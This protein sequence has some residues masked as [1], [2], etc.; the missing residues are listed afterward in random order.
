MPVKSVV[1][2]KAK[3]KMTAPAGSAS[4]SSVAGFVSPG[5]PVPSPS[6]TLSDGVL[7]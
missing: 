7:I 2:A 1:L 5:V 4:S 6:V 3:S